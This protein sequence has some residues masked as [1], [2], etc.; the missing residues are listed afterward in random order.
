VISKELNSPDF[1]FAKIRLIA[2]RTVFCPSKPNTV[3]PNSPANQK[4]VHPASL[5]F[6]LNPYPS[7]FLTNLQP[8]AQGSLS[9][10]SASGKN[11]PSLIRMVPALIVSA[12]WNLL[13]VTV[14][15]C[16]AATSTDSWMFAPDSSFDTYR[17]SF[18]CPH[19]VFRW[20]D[21]D[22]SSKRSLQQPQRGLNTQLI[23]QGSH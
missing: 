23:Q 2:L 19:S 20:K 12:I 18:R 14:I 8:V 11:V 21:F 17:P 5:I 3:A 6:R 7:R 10:R 4:N 13:S 9:N 15:H 22:L 1:R 16:F